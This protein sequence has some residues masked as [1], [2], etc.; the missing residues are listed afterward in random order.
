MA[1]DRQAENRIFTN[2]LTGQVINQ[3]L[4]GQVPPLVSR[5]KMSVMTSPLVSYAVQRLVDL[6]QGSSRFVSRLVS[7]AGAALSNAGRLSGMMPG[8]LTSGSQRTKGSPMW[9][10]LLDLNWFQRRQRPSQE[11]VYREA[12]GVSPGLLLSEK[13]PPEVAPY[14]SAFLQV[15][16]GPAEDIYHDFPEARYEIS[17]EKATGELLPYY[18]K[19]DSSLPDISDEPSPPDN[20]APSIPPVTPSA[21]P[22]IDQTAL[23]RDPFSLLPRTP[24][25]KTPELSRG[26]RIQKSDSGKVSGAEDRPVGIGQRHQESPLY[27]RLDQS[28]LSGNQQIIPERVSMLRPAGDNDLTVTGNKITQPA[29]QP[30]PAE[31]QTSGEP[32]LPANRRETTADVAGVAGVFTGG[33]KQAAVS[34]TDV[35]P[36]FPMEESNLPVYQAHEGITT[37]LRK[38]IDRVRQSVAPKQDE[39]PAEQTQAP[40]LPDEVPAP[41]VTERPVYQAAEEVREGRPPAPLQLSLH[42]VAGQE[43]GIAADSAGSEGMVSEP[44]TGVVSPHSGT[45]QGKGWLMKRVETYLP[46]LRSLAPVDLALRRPF[47]LPGTAIQKRDTGGSLPADVSQHYQSLPASGRREYLPSLPEEPRL[48]L[49]DSLYQADV[50]S[51]A[52]PPVIDSSGQYPADESPLEPPDSVSYGGDEIDRLPPVSRPAYRSSILDG[53]V[54]RSPGVSPGRYSRP[55]NDVTGNVSEP[56]GLSYTPRIRELWL[57]SSRHPVQRQ[58]DTQP[59]FTGREFE[60][61][62]SLSE[63]GVLSGVIQGAGYY[64]SRGV[65]DLALA[66]AGR[67][68]ETTSSTQSETRQASGESISEGATPEIDDIARDVY[69]I[70]RRRLIRERERAL[71]IS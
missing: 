56:E 58:P 61:V 42:R 53:I 70:L 38:V 27:R 71:G 57:P 6:G 29:P 35:P 12:T 5:F 40:S 26:S 48:G 22:L 18:G 23:H 4:T 49:P 64:G 31:I 9:Q 65:P 44:D 16:P 15:Q 67:Q 11:Q 19:E 2:P 7:N 8:Y 30:Y 46:R 3:R 45:Y 50:G 13:G 21:R 55:V 36:V 62:G 14:R 10:P 47:R 34:E 37:R 41:G 60:D 20:R 43:T 32:Y 33:E 28:I 51:E 63:E 24:P 52:W 59:G 66:P 17:S 25:V 39:S 68:A 69:R 1:P 54:Y